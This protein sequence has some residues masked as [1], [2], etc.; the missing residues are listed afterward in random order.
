MV[1]LAALCWPA[2]NVKAQ[3]APPTNFTV[4]NVTA[5]SALVTWTPSTSTNV[6][7][8]TLYRSVVPVTNFYTH[9]N[10]DQ[11]IGGWGTAN[12]DIHFNWTDLDPGT[13]YY[14]YLITNCT[15]YSTSDTVS[16]TFS[17]LPG[18]KKPVVT[19][20]QEYCAS[21][22]IYFNWTNP[23]FS[24]GDVYDVQIAQGLKGT[25]NLNDSST[26]EVYY[27]NDINVG[28]R[29]GFNNWG[30]EPNTDY[31]LAMRVQCSDESWSPWSKVLNK[32]TACEGVALPYAEDFDS[33]TGN[34]SN[35]QYCQSI[36]PSLPE[37]WTFFNTTEASCLKP[38]A[39]LTSSNTLAKSGN[40][41]MLYSTPETP[42]YAMLPKFTGANGDPLEL[43]FYYSYMDEN[44]SGTLTV[45]YI[46]SYNGYYFDPNSYNNFVA[47]DSCPVAA[48]MTLSR[49][50][51]SNLPEHA[52]LAFRFTAADESYGVV[53]D[54]VKVT[55]HCLSF[56]LPYTENFLQPD[57]L[58]SSRNW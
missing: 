16:F 20:P 35:N 56:T 28:S 52:R 12:Q 44:L 4:S 1:S 6:Q 48:G 51:I 34:I 29:L 3:C 19:L 49:L 23:N 33:Y 43:S 39:F 47:V 7:Q 11:S 38:V 54:E 27:Y 18:C 57:F 26:Y 40:G 37:C 50:T 32:H 30:V 36:F 42:I 21:N 15:D 5:T 9:T 55:T 17:T 31:S 46:T 25:F 24:T 8:Y 22:I 45:G 13:T 10:W 53:I 14:C 2:A 41:L 58:W